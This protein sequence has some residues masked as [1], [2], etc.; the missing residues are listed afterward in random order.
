MRNTNEL[1]SQGDYT[2][3]GQKI[4]ETG[5]AEST[6]FQWP[7]IFEGIMEK[8]KRSPEKQKEIDEFNQTGMFGNL[9]GRMRDAPSGLSQVSLRDPTTG[10]V[11]L[12]DKNVDSLFGS[13]TVEEQVDRKNK[14]IRDRLIAGKGL[15]TN[16]RDY[17][18]QTLGLDQQGNFINQPNKGSQFTDTIPTGPINTGQGQGPADWTPGSATYGTQRAAKATWDRPGAKGSPGHHWAQGGRVGYQNGELVE[19]QTDFIEG[20]QGANE[21][22]ETV[23]EGQGQPSREQLEALAMKIFQLPLEELDEQQLVVV[24]QTAMQGQ[25]M[26]ESVQEEDVQFVAQGGLAGLL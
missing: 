13:K 25:P 17:A 6:G 21:F 9:E 19:Q 23:V 8:F 1:T 11:I 14:W 24:Y 16:L 18:S 22:Q 3:G 26:Q 20:P 2:L 10:A 4:S 7:S 12:R 5:G 15:S